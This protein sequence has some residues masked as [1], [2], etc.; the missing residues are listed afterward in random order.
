MRNMS[1]QNQARE[2]RA[3]PKVEYQNSQLQ[4][5]H[6][7]QTTEVQGLALQFENETRHIAEAEV[8]SG[9]VAFSVV[10]SS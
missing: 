4:A 10:F 6:S 2:E 8:D 5:A 7:H 9:T 1:R 3:R